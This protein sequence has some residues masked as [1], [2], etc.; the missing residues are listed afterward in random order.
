LGILDP[1]SSNVGLQRLL[2]MRKA[3]VWR[4]FLIQRRKFS[5]TRNGWLATQCRSHQSPRKFPANREFY[6][7]TCDFGAPYTDFVAKKPLRCSHF[8][9]NSLRKLTGKIFQGTGNFLQVSGNCGIAHGV[10]VVSVHFS[11]TC[12]MARRRDLFSPSIYRLRRARW[13]ARSDHGRVRVR[14]SGGRTTR[15]GS[16]A[17]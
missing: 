13:R 15:R 9:C 12:L 11:H 1:K 4:A 16:A 5:E 14:L 7:E 2:A 3:R 6:R 8:S 17:T 10:S